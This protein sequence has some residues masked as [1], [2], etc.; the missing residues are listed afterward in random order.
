MPAPMAN[1]VPVPV[2]KRWR[3]WPWFWGAALLLSLLTLLS[4]VLGVAVLADYAQQG[5][6]VTING[7]EWD[8]AGLGG[9][10]G[11][12]LATVGVLAAAAVVLL[13]VPLC[14]LVALL[15]VVVAV[16]LALAAAL[17]A[18]ALSLSIV[19]GLVL[20]PLW[21]TFLMIRWAVRGLRRPLAA[22]PQGSGAHSLG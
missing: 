22:Q 3:L 12:T 13:V 11:G 21:L 18:I 4:A 5:G 17:L 8:G 16:G 1:L 19:A 6:H 20:A 10:F 2:R 7:N 9:T 14:L 15:A